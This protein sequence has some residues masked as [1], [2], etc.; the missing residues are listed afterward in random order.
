[1]K[2]KPD[3]RHIQE[4]MQ[5]GRLSLDGYTGQDTRS[6]DAIM[7]ADQT[8]LRDLNTTAEAMGRVMRRITR[9]GMEAQGEP[10]RL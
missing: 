6:L 10:R 9:A 8:V 1:M 5:P 4:D 7:N 2:L 3:A